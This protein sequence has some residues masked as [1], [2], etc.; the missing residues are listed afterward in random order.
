M[1]VRFAITGSSGTGK[2]TLVKLLADKLGLPIVGEGMREYLERTQT[3]L[4]SL[5]K[6]GLKNLMYQLWEEHKEAEA[7]AGSFIADRCSY[8]FAAFWLFYGFAYE[9]EETDRWMEEVLQPGRYSKVVVLPWGR[10][11]LVADGVRTAD[12]WVQLH[13]QSLLQGLLQQV[14]AP[15]VWLQSRSQEE[16]LREVLSLL[17]G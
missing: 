13:Y 14:E 4:H 1:Q 11:P 16:R 17:A 3:D 8:D 6:Q 15:T 2:S 10:I 5:G 9:G 12:R 7:S